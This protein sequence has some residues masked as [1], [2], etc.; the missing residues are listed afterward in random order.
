MGEATARN[1]AQHYGSLEALMLADADS[2]QQVPDVG[3]VVAENIRQ[4]FLQSHNQDI[5][6]RLLE[7]GFSWPD[8]EVAEQGDQPLLGQVF[9]LTGTFTAM[10]RDEAKTQL[11]A[12]GAKVTGSVS[13][14]TTAVIAGDA[15]GSKVDKAG[16]LGVDVL[17]EAGLLVLLNTGLGSRGD[18]EAQPVS[19]GEDSP[20]QQGLF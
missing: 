18:E 12:L 17:D 19:T 10:K 1:L 3:G 11:I 4:F 15:P 9:V 20:K 14:K 5:I 13:K 8:I 2:L 6:K 7:Q 16:E